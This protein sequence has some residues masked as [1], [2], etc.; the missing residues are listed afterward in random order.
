MF[1]KKVVA[2]GRITNGKVEIQTAA[3][4]ET[5]PASWEQARVEAEKQGEVKL[6]KFFDGEMKP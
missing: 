6:W 2:V 3:P 4:V 1:E 5:V